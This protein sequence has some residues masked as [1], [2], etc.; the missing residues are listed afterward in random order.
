MDR[1]VKGTKECD[2]EMAELML[3]CTQESYMKSLMCHALEGCH[4]HDWGSDMVAKCNGAGVGLGR[5]E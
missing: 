2:K 1:S 5:K 3:K 4:F